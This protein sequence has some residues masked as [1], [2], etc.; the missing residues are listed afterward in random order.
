MC[1]HKLLT[2]SIPQTKLVLKRLRKN[3]SFC[4][5]VSWKVPWYSANRIFW[6]IPCAS[7]GK[8]ILLLN[9]MPTNNKGQ[10]NIVTH[11]TKTWNKINLCQTN[12]FYY[13]HS[14]SKTHCLNANFALNALL[15]LWLEDVNYTPNPWWR[16]KREWMT[17]PSCFGSPAMTTSCQCCQTFSPSSMITWKIS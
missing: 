15:R 17:G 14:F 3:E 1:R 9:E 11:K 8:M 10:S 13:S 4:Q 16:A 6:T 12:L 2:R 7:L 5:G